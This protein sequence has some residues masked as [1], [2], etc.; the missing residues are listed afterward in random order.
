M[1]RELEQELTKAGLVRLYFNA[2]PE[3]MKAIADCVE[4]RVGT[5]AQRRAVL[6]IMNQLI[7]MNRQRANG[8][9]TSKLFVKLN[10]NVQGLGFDVSL[11]KK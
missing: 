9:P 8:S 10:A 2:T 6:T 7:A 3:G 5:Q 1:I 11:L 4:G